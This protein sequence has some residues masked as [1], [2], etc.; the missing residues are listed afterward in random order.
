MSGLVVAVM[1]P[2][3]LHA[4]LAAHAAEVDLLA[5]VPGVGSVVVAPYEEPS[6]VR[7]RRSRPGYVPAPEDVVPLTAEQSDALGRADVALALDLPLGVAEVAPRL[8]WVQAAGTG[9]GHLASAGLA[10][11][12]IRLANG[13]G[14]SADEIA[15]H[16]LA[17]I[18]EHWKRLPELARAQQERDWRPLYGR[19]LAGSVVVVVGWGAIGRAVGER[20]AAL[21]VVVRVVRRSGRPDAVTDAAADTVVGPDAVADV[22]VGPDGLSSVLAGADAVV[23]AVPETASTVGLLDRTAL[24]ALP[25]GALVVN[26]GRG[27]AVDESALDAALA[28]GHLGGAALDVFAVEPLPAGSPLWTRRG[29][30]LS[31]HCASVPAETARRVHALLRENIVRWLQNEALINEI[32]LRK[33]Y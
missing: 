28:S 5:A 31:A 4:S 15:E 2:V 33:G 29:A 7:T 23:L 22:V 9:V 25:P 8:R 16:V 6:E 11:A 3:R 21:G 17:R 20:L 24:A 12:G 13:A 30:R 32:D 18:L 26:V 27:S 1:D 14:T 10:E 19:R